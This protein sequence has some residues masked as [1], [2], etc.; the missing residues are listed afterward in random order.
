MPT[1]ITLY[2]P[3]GHEACAAW[4]RQQTP[5]VVAI[6]LQT[7]EAIQTFLTKVSD[8]DVALQIKTLEEAHRL[9]LEEAICDLQCKFEDQR[10]SAQRSET[11]IIEA[12]LECAKRDND[13]LVHEVQAS[14]ATTD[15][16]LCA[17]RQRLESELEGQRA[18]L[19]TVQ[20]ERDGYRA[21]QSE[22]QAR[23]REES[24]ARIAETR[25]MHD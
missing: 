3:D 21:D 8:E 12:Q 7:S 16:R 11:A 18:L 6:A 15:E 10:H 4:I 9:E 2:I 24:D 22:Y 20:R 25:T 1:A 19:T 14:A 17:Q 23:A 5:E 13:R